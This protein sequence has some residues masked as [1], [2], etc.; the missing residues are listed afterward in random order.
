MIVLVGLI[1]I[2][3]TTCAS[4]EAEQL[5]VAG[6]E[7]A[8]V[9]DFVQAAGFFADASRADPDCR[10]LRLNLIS[11][12]LHAGQLDEARQELEKLAGQ[13]GQDPYFEYLFGM[14]LLREG[15]ADN[16]S[17]HFRKVLEIDPSDAE[18][19]CQ[20]GLIEFRR[21]DLDAAVDYFKQALQRDPANP[22]ALYNEARALKAL[23]RDAQSR[24]LMERFKTLKA[25]QKPSPGG[26]MGE[27]YLIPGKYA[28]LQCEG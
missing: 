4:K 3:S 20:L 6:C 18:T 2:L 16:A 17:L 11:A 15:H 8:A 13:A 22:A 25:S 5:N 28:T 23:G 14:L 21:G 1:L 9:F 7:R 26:G 19:F 10:M 27:P 24:E 12:R